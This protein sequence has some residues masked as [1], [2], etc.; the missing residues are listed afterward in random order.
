LFKSD[1]KIESK[2][3]LIDILPSIAKSKFCKLTFIFSINL[4]NRLISYI[5]TVD[6]DGIRPLD[7]SLK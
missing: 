7:S 3:A 1:L 4:L 2:S 6:N 5:S